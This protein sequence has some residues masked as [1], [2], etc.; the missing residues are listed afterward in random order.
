MRRKI[1]ER[2]TCIEKPVRTWCHLTHDYGT[3]MAAGIYVRASSQP[4]FQVWSSP[5]HLL[6]N[7]FE[8]RKRTFWGRKNNHQSYGLETGDFSAIFFSFHFRDRFQPEMGPLFR[9]T[10]AI[11]TGVWIWVSTHCGRQQALRYAENSSS[12]N[13]ASICRASN[14]TCAAC[15]A[16]LPTPARL[17]H[18]HELLGRG[19]CDCVD[20]STKAVTILRDHKIYLVEDVVAVWETAVDERGR[21]SQ[22]EEKTT[23]KD[24]P[25]SVK[26][27]CRVSLVASTMMLLH[28]LRCSGAASPM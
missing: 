13:A 2:N 8:N 9:S 25:P 19:C 24:N 12:T 17:R 6:W 1:Q 4:K 7:S 18:H 15:C 26:R 14:K 22:R 5:G 28:G 20:Y 16:L 23:P 27:M 3:T 10:S 21:H 11:E